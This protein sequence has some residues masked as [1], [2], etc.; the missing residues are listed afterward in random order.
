MIRVGLSMKG[1][2]VVVF[3]FLTFL[4]VPAQAVRVKVNNNQ[5]VQLDSEQLESLKRQP[6]IYYVKFPP[7]KLLSHYSLVEIPAEL[8][9]GYL[10]AAPKDLAAALIAIGA[11][12]RS[13][14][15]VTR[16][17]TPTGE[18]WMVSLYFGG[19]MPDDGDV[20]GK[21]YPFGL[22]LTDSDKVDYDNKFTFGGRFGYWSTDA[23]WA[24]F[25]LDVSYLKLDASGI[26]T[27]VIPVSP[28]VMFR[29]PGERLQPYIGI[30]P[31]IFLSDID[32]DIQLSGVD[33]QFSD[34]HVDVGLDARA[35][36]AW[37]VF[38][39]IA[40]FGEYRFAYYKGNYQDDISAAGTT[41]KVKIETDIKVHNFLFGLSYSF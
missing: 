17:V 4:A 41:T 21:A 10:V 19:A 31:G 26:K 34:K 25:A 13:Q 29:Y 12:D 33:R 2:V 3:L 14:A 15:A 36:M 6:G 20:D 11:V 37:R 39:S 8:G 9:G 27:H 24:G 5:V 16:Q 7:E 1:L 23:N 32:V 18:R 22:T 38:R 28:L 40:V 35:G 30:G